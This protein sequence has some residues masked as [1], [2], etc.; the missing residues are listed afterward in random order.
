MKVAGFTFIRNAIQFD[1]PIVEAVQSILPLCDYVVVVVGK[2]TDETLKLVQSIDSQ[3]IRII[4]TIWDDTLKTGGAVLAVETNKA[5]DAVGDDADWC[6]YIQGDEC[7]HEKFLPTVK[8]AMER[9]QNDADTE[10]LL[11]NYVH[12]YGS[13]DYVATSRA[14]YRQEIRIIKNDKTIRSYRDAQGFRKHN[15]KLKVRAVEAAIYHYGWVK[16]PEAQQR[17][18][19]TMN[20]FWHSEEEVRARVPDVSEFDYS[21]IDDLVHF[22]G[23]HPLV[24]QPRIHALN[25]QFSFDPTQRALSFKERFSRFFEKTTGWR[26][27]EYRN[28]KKIGKA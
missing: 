18:Q 11:F 13:Y 5:F 27:G 7:L 4:E 10:G 17:K 22:E 6:I 19:L 15:K 14:W 25:W 2:S 16:H 28:F 20:G 23:T 1:Y 3:K 9:W 21:K 12:F 8:M 26:I 24:M